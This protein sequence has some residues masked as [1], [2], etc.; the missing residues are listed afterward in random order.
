MIRSGVLVHSPRATRRLVAAVPALALVLAAACSSNA[1][2][3]ASP[4]TTSGDQPRAPSTTTTSSTRSVEVEIVARYQAFWEA[5]FEANEEPVDP[6]HPGLREYATGAQLENVIDE[7]RRNR[8]EG[9]A[10]RPV[11]GEERES[12]VRLLEVDGHQARLQECVVDYGVTYRVATGEVIDDD[13]ITQSVDATMRQVDGKW[14]LASTRLLQ[15]WEGVA[16][17]AVGQN[18]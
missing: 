8:S 6:D 11:N 16:G 17:C 2:G 13:V 12:T 3:N 15:E 5:R 10:F 9:V 7:T 1:D 14:K 18:S 4:T